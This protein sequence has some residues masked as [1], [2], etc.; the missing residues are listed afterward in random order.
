MKLTHNGPTPGDFNATPT[1]PQPDPLAAFLCT[2]SR[3]SIE[4][5]ERLMVA[6]YGED[7]LPGTESRRIS[8][9]GHSC[10]REACSRIPYKRG[11]C[12][13]HFR[14]WERYHQSPKPRPSPA[15]ILAECEA[16][17][18]AFVEWAGDE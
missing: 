2:Y 12:R 4:D 3:F 17:L 16:A 13:P 8:Q 6:I 11:L 18:A 9:E 5:H 14:A 15:E 10:S 1:M 7:R